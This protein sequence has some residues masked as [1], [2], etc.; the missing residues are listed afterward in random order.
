MTEAKT[1][2]IDF[3]TIC[4]VNIIGITEEELE[5]MFQY[6]YP[7]QF[8]KILY[9]DGKA[10]VT[11]P[12]HWTAMYFYLDH[13]HHVNIAWHVEEGQ[14][15]D[16]ATIPIYI[17]NPQDPDEVD[18]SYICNEPEGYEEQEDDDC[19]NEYDHPDICPTCRQDY[20]DYRGRCQCC[21]E[22]HI[23]LFGSSRRRVIF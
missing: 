23:G 12:C 22:M 8:T 4:T 17:S 14:M 1:T 20:I 10:I 21:T 5:N 9:E 19:R 13:K 15:I 6:T 3:N 18:E 11:C 7:D 2:L 16:P